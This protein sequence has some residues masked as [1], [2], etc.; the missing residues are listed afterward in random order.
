[1]MRNQSTHRRIKS[2]CL[3]L[4]EFWHLLLCC[5][6]LTEEVGS[7]ALRHF[8]ALVSISLSQGLKSTDL[9]SGLAAE[10]CNIFWILLT[11][12]LSEQKL[13]NALL[14]RHLKYKARI[15]CSVGLHFIVKRS[16][17]ITSLRLMPSVKREILSLQ[18][19]QH[20]LIRN[21]WSLCKKLKT[22]NHNCAQYNSKDDSP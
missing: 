14:P 22:F 8:L 19:H 4:K 21:L 20:I 1:M 13:I 5:E 9:S 12:L 6:C 15:W 17:F 3:S 7:N 11:H 2:R 18:W 10:S 16:G